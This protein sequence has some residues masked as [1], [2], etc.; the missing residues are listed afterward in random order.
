[1]YSGAGAERDNELQGG[2][3]QNTRTFNTGVERERAMIPLGLSKEIR[4]ADLVAGDLVSLK[5]SKI[6]PLD[7]SL[8]FAGIVEKVGEDRGQYVASVI[9]RGALVFRLA[10]LSPE[11]RKGTGVLIG[12]MCAVENLERGMAIV[13]IR[14]PADARR[15]ELGGPIPSR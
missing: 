6:V 5:E 10:G 15:F 13:G 3:R 4:H 7:P 1:L 9:N 8:E 2:C 14:L 11:T 12:E